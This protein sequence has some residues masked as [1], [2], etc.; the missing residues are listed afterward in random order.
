MHHKVPDTDADCMSGAISTVQQETA[1]LAQS[2][3]SSGQF[4]HQLTVY[5][6][7]TQVICHVL[8]VKSIFPS[9]HFSLSSFWSA[10]EARIT[11][12]YPRG[13]S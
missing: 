11:Q 12:P 13:F 1:R 4:F 7:Q 2:R 10:W 5:H 9:A 8:F 6:P 3:E